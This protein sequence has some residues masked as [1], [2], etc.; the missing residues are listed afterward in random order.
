VVVCKHKRIG[1]WHGIVN[2]R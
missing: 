2:K 1:D